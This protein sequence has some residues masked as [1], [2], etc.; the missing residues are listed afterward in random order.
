VDRLQ[1]ITTTSRLR[2]ARVIMSGLN[3][4]VSN[5]TCYTKAGEKLHESFIPCG[6][7]AFGHVTCCGKGDRCLAD[8]A[9]YGKYGTG[10]GSDLTYFGGCTDPDYKAGTCP[11]KSGIGERIAVPAPRCGE[12]RRR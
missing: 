6:N 3:I 2:L 12:E 9:C 11:S 4:L 10:Y 8:N 1:A 5:G 7:A